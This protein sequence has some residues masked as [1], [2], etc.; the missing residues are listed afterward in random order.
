MTESI[1]NFDMKAIQY[2]FP[3]RWR[4]AVFMH[5]L[6]VHIF[7]CL[8]QVEDMRNN[9]KAFYHLRFIFLINI[10]LEITSSDGSY[11]EILEDSG[12]ER[13]H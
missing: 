5:C 2:A 8:M 7:G 6:Q 10:H 1:K 9:T 13:C 3:S 4:P 12:L 11:S